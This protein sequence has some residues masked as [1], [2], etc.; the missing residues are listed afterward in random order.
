MKTDKRGNV[1]KTGLS[2]HKH[3]DR[4]EGIE[5]R[6]DTSCKEGGRKRVPTEGKKSGM[7]LCVLQHLKKSK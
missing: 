2:G 6:S 5:K 7:S 1:T 4:S 3:K